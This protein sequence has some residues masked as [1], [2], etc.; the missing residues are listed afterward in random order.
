MLK[1]ITIYLVAVILFAHLADAAIIHGSIYDLSLKK[2]TGVRVEINTSQRQFLIAQNSSYSFNVPTGVYT[3]QA[4]LMQKGDVIESIQENITIKD[5]N[6]YTLDLILLPDIEH[7]VEEEDLDIGET[8]LEKSKGNSYFLILLLLLS[9][10]VPIGIYKGVKF[11]EKNKKIQK[12][13]LIENNLGQII[14]IIKV[15]GGR[16]TQKEIRKKMPFSEA[17]ISLMITELE[18]E[19]KI[20]KIKRGRGNIIILNKKT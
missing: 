11:L 14:D 17:K 10:A 7:G 12:E 8:I 1:Q 20:K 18:N 13:A 6:I 3:L 19:G 5:N 4:K 9:I 16:T 2:L 15:G